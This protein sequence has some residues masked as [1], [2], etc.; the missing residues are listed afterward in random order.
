MALP[1]SGAADAP[2]ERLPEE[3]FADVLGPDMKAGFNLR[4]D[5]WSG[6]LPTG[7]TKPIRHQFSRGNDYHFYV[8]TDVHGA[9]MSVHIYDQDGNLAEDRAW[10]RDSNGTSFAGA[11]IR[12]KSTGSYYLILKVDASPEKETAWAMAY[13]YK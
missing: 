7:E 10:Q 9:R 13:A 1:R 3:M 6:N 12:A 8:S 11:E 2:D 5:T 4:S